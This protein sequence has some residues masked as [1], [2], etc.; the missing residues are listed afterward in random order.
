M[1]Q[2]FEQ[3]NFQ[4]VLGL[5]G[6]INIISG[7]VFLIYPAIFF[8][9]FFQPDLTGG[10]F[11]SMAL[12]NILSIQLWSVVLILGF[13]YIWASLQVMSNRLFVFIGGLIES[14]SGLAWIMTYFQSP[15]KPALLVLAS[16]H[17]VF[18]LLFVL[19]F[20]GTKNSR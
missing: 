8:R 17:A 6:M 19:F 18:G 16:L 10:P 1:K 5:A 20:F 3:R 4:H 15:A 12:A 14:A 11:V 9:F 2:L 13:G 7:I